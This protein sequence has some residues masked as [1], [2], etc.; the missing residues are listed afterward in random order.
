MQQQG[1]VPPP[2]EPRIAK[3]EG[4]VAALG[5]ALGLLLNL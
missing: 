1:L 5:V 3:V 2:P 4:N